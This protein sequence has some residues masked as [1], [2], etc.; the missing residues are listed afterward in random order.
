MTEGLNICDGRILWVCSSSK[1]LDICR[2]SPGF[3]YQ[4]IYNRRMRI[5]SFQLLPALLATVVFP[6]QALDNDFEINDINLNEENFLDIKA[7]RFR[8]S[9]EYQ[10]YDYNSAWR[11]TGASL[12][13]DLAFVQNELKLQKDMSEY[14]NVRLETKQ[15]VFYA[16]NTL[17]RPTV[18]VEVYPW[19]GNLGFSLLG[20]PAYEKRD[21]D[22]G[23]AVIWGRRPWNYLRFEYLEVDN[24][25]NQKNPFDATY[26]S[27]QPKSYRL[28][29]TWQFA[30]SCK[31]VFDFRNETQ[32]VLLDPDSNGR[33]SHRANNYFVLFDY[34]RDP[35]SVIGITLDG[36]SL[37]KSREQ[38]GE[39]RQQAT[40]YVSVDIYWVSGMGRAY[41]WRLGSQYDYLRNDIN[42]GINPA[43]KLDYFMKTLQVYGTAYHPFNT[44]MAWDIGLYV[45]DVEERQN[46]VNDSSRNTVN[47]GVEAKLRMGFVYRSADGRSTLQFNISLN[48]DDPVNDPGDGGGIS[49]QSVF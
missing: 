16:D 17:M 35:S 24:L 21:M 15:Q 44:H 12:D 6:V 13:G 11:I 48:A 2:E 3:Y 33:F 37:D 29:G 43:D 1:S 40:D 23:G 36:F 31:L 47:Q 26:Y 45:G 8:K 39:D 19:A 49:F 30:G 41:E 4:F 14:V 10:W 46:Y 38:S 18:E 25:Y 32:G 5:R 34:Q 42:D 27:T 22:L 20:T 9:L 28:E 7:H